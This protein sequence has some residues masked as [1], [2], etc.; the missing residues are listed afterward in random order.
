MQKIV[1]F[2]NSGS[3][4]S[5]LAK[6]YAVKFGLAH[7]DL[8]SLTWQN[9]CPPVRSPLPVSIDNINRF[10]NEN[11]S[12]V[13]EGS[14]S[15]LLAVLMSRADEVIFLNPSVTTCINNRRSRP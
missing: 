9:T 12:W 2:G 8:D 5:T 7:L 11:S 10:T 1:I 6:E 14:Y 15:D 13:I 4:K 3:G